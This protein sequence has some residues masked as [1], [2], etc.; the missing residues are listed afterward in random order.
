MR[1]NGIELTVLVK[2]R[3][4]QEY[5]HEGNTFVEGRSGSKFELCL[6]NLNSTKVE[7]VVSVDGRSITDGKQAGTQSTGYLL[8]PFQKIVI[9]GWK[10]SGSQAAEFVFSGKNESYS[11]VMSGGDSTNNGVIGV[12][13]YGEK[14][15]VQRYVPPSP[16]FDRFGWHENMWQA[17]GIS[18]AGAVDCMYSA[19]PMLES[20]CAAAPDT[21]GAT[22]GS[23]TRGVAQNLGTGFGQATDFVTRQVSFERGTCITTMALYYDNARGLK[24]R[25]IEVIRK[26]EVSPLPNPFPASG[27]TP[28]PGWRG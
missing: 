6:R 13:V 17:R 9:P 5:N 15:A 11:T 22:K 4:I 24:A 8:D 23:V 21:R 10:L 18:P 25:G 26:K 27:C 28:P 19:N 16:I 2:D 7:V 14:P 1:S 3:P 20:V 12:M